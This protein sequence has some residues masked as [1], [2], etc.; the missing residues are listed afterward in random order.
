MKRIV[1]FFA[2]AALLFTLVN[3]GCNQEKN[4]K[5][6]EQTD[7]IDPRLSDLNKQIENSPD[8]HS[9]WHK[10]ALLY[11]EMNMPYEALTDI[12]KALQLNPQ[13]TTYTITLAD[14][15]FSMGHVDNCRKAL[16]SAQD[17]DPA[18]V[19]PILKLAELD[20]ILKDYEKMNLYLNKVLEI[21]NSNAQVFY[22]RGIAL[23]E[24]GDSLAA[25]RSFQTAIS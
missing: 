6:N 7:T 12:N 24:Q 17:N 10:R 9:L 18:N 19:E 23:K 4:K 1:F 3:T 20:L 13:N 22:M 14:I 25:L 5:Q 15:Y 8:D 11:L 16:I 21:D 2:I